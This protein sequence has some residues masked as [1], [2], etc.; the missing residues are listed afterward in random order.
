M[1]LCRRNVTSHVAHQT[2]GP[3][4]LSEPFL[5]DGGALINPPSTLGTLAFRPRRTRNPPTREKLRRR[6]RVENPAPSTVRMLSPTRE[7]Q[8]AHHGELVNRLRSMV[9]ERRIHVSARQLPFLEGRFLPPHHLRTRQFAR[10]HA[11]RDPTD[12]MGR[13][14]SRQTKKG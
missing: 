4:P 5:L 10:A 9:E 13:A 11:F 6:V 2:L 8:P 1:G 12:T 14:I 3:F 7:V